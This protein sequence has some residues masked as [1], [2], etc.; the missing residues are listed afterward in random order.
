VDAE[1]VDFACVQEGG[2]DF[3]AAHHPDMFAGLCAQA[4][5]EWFDRLVYEFERSAVLPRAGS[6]K[7]RSS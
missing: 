3:A 5:G 6:G 1:L 4:L 2:D 7:R